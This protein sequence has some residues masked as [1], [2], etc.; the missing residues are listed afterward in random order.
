MR[1]RYKV[2]YTCNLSKRGTSL[3]DNPVLN[4]RTTL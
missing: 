3:V 2:T 1:P 4:C